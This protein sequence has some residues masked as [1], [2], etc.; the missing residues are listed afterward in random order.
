MS[1]TEDQ[2]RRP[3]VETSEMGCSSQCFVS[4]QS[5]AEAG[6]TTFAARVLH[7]TNPTMTPIVLAGMP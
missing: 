6:G 5:H 2:L 1:L 7:P 3:D 4:F